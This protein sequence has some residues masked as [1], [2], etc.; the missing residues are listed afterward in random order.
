MLWYVYCG[1]VVV[2]GILYVGTVELVPP[3]EWK[4]VTGIGVVGKI[5]K[6]WFVDRDVGKLGIVVEVV[7]NVVVMGKVA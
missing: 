5:G 2:L 3:H 4:G 6:V 7:E 1:C